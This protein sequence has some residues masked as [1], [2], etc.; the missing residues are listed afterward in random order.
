MSEGLG[1]EI[2]VD[3][4]GDYA[5]LRQTDPCGDEL[6]TIVHIQRHHIALLVALALKISS[7]K[8]KMAVLLSLTR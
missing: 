7:F 6:G 8:I 1:T 2:V 4:S 5:Q 3:P